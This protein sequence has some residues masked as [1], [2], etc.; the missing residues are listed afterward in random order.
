MELYKKEINGKSVVKPR[1]AIV[2][3]KHNMQIINP[4]EDVILADGWMRVVEPNPYRPSEE[5]MARNNR[6]EEIAELKQM[7]SQTDYKVIKCM[8]ASLCGNML[9]YDIY[10]LHEERNELRMRINELES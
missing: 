2:V 7:L 3:V 8:E 6:N 5:E 9:P 1:N 10:A 4:S